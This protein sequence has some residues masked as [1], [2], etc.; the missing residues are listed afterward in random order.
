MTK[1]EKY[2]TA[3]DKKDPDLFRVCIDHYIFIV[4]TDISYALLFSQITL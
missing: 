2:Q 3:R 4:I 1:Q